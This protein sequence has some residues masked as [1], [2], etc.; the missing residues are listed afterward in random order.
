[1][2]GMTVFDAGVLIAHLDDA[3]AFHESATAF[4]E[5]ND[6]FEFW[7]TPVTLAECLVRPARHGDAARVLAALE[8]LRFE[9]FEVTEADALGIASIR[10][11]TDLRMS[12][13]LVVHA[14]ERLEVEIVTTDRALAT[15]ARSRGLVTT[16]LSAA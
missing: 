1:M 3:D 13:A 5:E 16:L 10:A 15:A 2:A 6:Q 4:I 9:R 11:A 14:A 12:D 8:R 7:V